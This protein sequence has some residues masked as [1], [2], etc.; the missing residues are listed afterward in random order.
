MKFRLEK[1]DIVPFD[2]KALT[3]EI[4]GAAGAEQ[5]GRPVSD[6]YWQNLIIR[7]NRRIDNATSGKALSISWAAR[8]AIPGVV[9]ILSFYIGLHYYAPDLK[10]SDSL[11]SVVLS[12]PGPEVDSL[13]ADPSQLDPTISVADLGG[14][15]FD[16]PKEQ[17]A[18]Y[19]IDHGRPSALMEA[20][21]D[22]QV[23]EVL[24]TL[25]SRKDLSL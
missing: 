11:T 12:L 10:G 14:N 23:N 5:S 15:P 20:M 13:L 1:P 4:R 17:M 16:I 22:D 25:G 6:A 18:E 2:E 3:D 19:F 9:A 8:V 7:T 21:T 24:M